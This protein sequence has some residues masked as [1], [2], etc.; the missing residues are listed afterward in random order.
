MVTNR[1][2]S[3]AS[4]LP[5]EPVHAPGTGPGRPYGLDRYTGSGTAKESNTRYRQLIAGGTTALSVA[6]DLPTRMGHDSDAPVATGEVGRTGVAV[7]SI[8]DM[9]VLFGGIPLDRVSTSLTVDAP[10]PLLLLLYQLVA[11]EQGVAAGLL[12]GAVRNDVL[13]EYVA[14]GTYIFPPKPSL[15]LAADVFTYCRA[16]IPQ[17]NTISVSGH[18]MAEA[19]ASSVQEIAFTLADGIE[20][21]RTAVAA[22]MDVDEFAP[23][24]SFLFMARTTFQEEAAMFSAARRIWARVMREEFGARNPGSLMPRFRAQAAGGQ[25]TARRPEAD[26]VRVAPQEPGV[27][28]IG[29]TIDDVEAAAVELMRRIEDFGGAVAA[30]EH[31][32]QTGEIEGN[33]CRAVE[34]ADSGEHF[35]VQVNRF[36]LGEGEFHEPFLIAPCIEDRQAERLAKLRAWRDQDRVDRHLAGLQKA[37]AGD[38]SVLYPMKDALSVGATVGEVCDALREIW[39]TC[40]PSGPV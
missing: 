2:R 7:D 24:L 23:R 33:A 8:D 13:Q 32:Y 17:W 14:R 1:P 30:I 10:A 31:G 6:F 35:A 4:G 22:G 38:D 36:R 20:Y 21:V 40:A 27:S 39:G 37:A 12:T 28:R 19:G 3:S 29:G 15:R 5:V 18:R 26:P 11:E 34:E 16:E 9:R 25:F